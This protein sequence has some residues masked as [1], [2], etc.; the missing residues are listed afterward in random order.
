VNSQITQISCC[1]EIQLV[2][3]NVNI[4]NKSPQWACKAIFLTEASKRMTGYLFS[5]K[6]IGELIF[7]GFSGFTLIRVST[8]LKRHKTVADTVQISE[9]FISDLKL[10]ATMHID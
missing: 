4:V 8:K 1:D 10:L 7:F 2:N 9:H 3:K 5:I 6:F